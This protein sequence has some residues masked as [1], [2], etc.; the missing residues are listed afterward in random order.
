VCVLLLLAHT[1][2]SFVCAEC[3]CC[4]AA[5]T[6]HTQ[7]CCVCVI[8]S[9]QS[10]SSARNRFETKIFDFSFLEAYCFA[11]CV[12]MHSKAVHAYI[13][14]VGSPPYGGLSTPFPRLKSMILIASM[15]S[16]AKH[17]VNPLRGFTFD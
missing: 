6:K 17:A 10:F 15:L 9:V 4:E 3:V 11:V 16:K 12:S 1:K 8:T 2:R 5:H 14:G 13:I 7:L